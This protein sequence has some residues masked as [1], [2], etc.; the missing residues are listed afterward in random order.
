M[1][2]KKLTLD[3]DTLV[4][5]TPETAQQV[6][7]GYQSVSSPMP[8]PQTVSSPAPQPAKHHHKHHQTVSSVKPI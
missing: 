5:L 1:K 3:L 2:T 6:N 8:G 4:E 7:G